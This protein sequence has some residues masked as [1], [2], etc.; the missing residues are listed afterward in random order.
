M[1]HYHRRGPLDP[2]KKI[3]VEGQGMNRHRPW[4]N[5]DG[6]KSPMDRF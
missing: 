4:Q 2:S 1:L 5:K 6:D 3:P